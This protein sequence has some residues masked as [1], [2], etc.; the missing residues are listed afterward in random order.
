MKSH[1]LL[2]KL[3]AG[4]MQNVKFKDFQKLVEEFGFVLSRI[5]G[6]HHIYTHGE[7]QDIINL[8]NVKGY[9][10]PYQIRQALKLAE[11]HNLTLES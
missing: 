8:Q 11:I 6:S 3:L 4:D 5:S 10:K 9:A 2:L 7:I 1:K